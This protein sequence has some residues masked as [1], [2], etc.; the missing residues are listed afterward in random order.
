M[1]ST[2]ARNPHF[3]NIKTFD[4]CLLIRP[5][6]HESINQL[7][8]NQRNQG[9]IDEVRENAYALSEQLGGVAVKKS[10][11]GS[12]HAIPAVAVGTICKKAQVQCIPMPR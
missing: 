11:H 7:E 8:D 5:V 6:S 2:V 3:R 9:N 12:G 1:D 4:F 10:L